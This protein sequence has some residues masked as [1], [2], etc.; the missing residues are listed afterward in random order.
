M[1]NIIQEQHV[2]REQQ[3]MNNSQQTNLL[4]RLQRQKRLMFLQ[5]LILSWPIKQINNTDLITY[6]QAIIPPR[7]HLEENDQDYN[8]A[9]QIN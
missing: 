7:Q 3:Q 6:Y 9:Q 1:F 2:N 4:H 5:Q 8:I